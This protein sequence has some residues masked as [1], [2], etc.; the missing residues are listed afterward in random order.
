MPR[1]PASGLASLDVL[2]RIAALGKAFQSPGDQETGPAGSNPAVELA[3]K[4]WHNHRRILKS[5]IGLGVVVAAGWIPVQALLETSSTEAVI[6]AR[7]ITLRS[8]I[9]GEVGPIAAVTAGSQVNPGTVLV[10]VANVRADR[11]RLDDLRRL[12][13]ELE[14]DIKTLQVRRADLAALQTDLRQQTRA[15]RAA[16]MDQLKARIAEIGSDITAAEAKLEEAQQSLTRARSLDATGSGTKVSLEKARR[17]AT[18][19]QETLLSLGHR[20][21][22][23]DI[24]L[25]ALDSGIYV[26]DSY[27]DRPQS[28]QRADDIALRLNE[29]DADIGHRQA[30]LALLRTELAGERERYAERSTARLT[31]PVVGSVWEVMTAPGE[32]V[33]RGQDL[34]RLLDC[35]GLVVTATVGETA[36]NNL[37]IGDRARFRFRGDGK[38]Y[39]GRILGL[40][41]VATAAANL[42]IQPSALAKEPYRVTVGVP[43]L[44]KAAQCDVGRTG[45]VTFGK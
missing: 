23:L 1:K 15:F 30:R 28:L 44:A 37:R 29:L 40:T 31:S 16:R 38:S 5:L 3:R 13:D 21:K 20:R 32:S 8:P 27:N 36:Y 12:V 9:E 18:V 10:N 19:A 4:T 22:S 25:A 11:G 45:R 17:D 26:G 34:V 43:E 35:S 14:S 2:G 42:A 33:A 24:E 41:G 6:N 7:L 39:E